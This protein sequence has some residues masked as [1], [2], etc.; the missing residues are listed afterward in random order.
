[1]PPGYDGWGSE[2]L[3]ATASER[4]LMD[5]RIRKAAKAAVAAGCR[6]PA[7]RKDHE[8]RLL[9]AGSLARYIARSG[10]DPKAALRQYLKCKRELDEFDLVER[11]FQ[12]LRESAAQRRQR[13]RAEIQADHE[14]GLSIRK[15]ADTRGVPKSTVARSV[16]RMWDT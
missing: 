4:S 11:V 15:I 3:P 13:L 8:Y 1:V 12:V 10:R 9:L 5:A 6:P 2:E 14:A 7:T 16:S